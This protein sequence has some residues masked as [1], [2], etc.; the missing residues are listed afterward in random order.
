RQYDGLCRFGADEFLITLPG[1]TMS[2]A[3]D[4]AKKIQNVV[5][6]TEF[7][8]NKLKVRFFTG[9]A[10][11]PENCSG[12]SGL[13]TAAKNALLEAKRENRT[14]VVIRLTEKFD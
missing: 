2:S 9:V 1:T 10:N 3:I 4:A 14:D 5:K 13:L 11:F 6:E 8:Q 7:T 12:I